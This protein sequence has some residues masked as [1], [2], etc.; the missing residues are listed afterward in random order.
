MSLGAILPL[1]RD[2]AM[3][4]E[5]LFLFN[6]LL[7][8][9]S[10]IFVSLAFYAVSEESKG[11]ML[12]FIVFWLL[13]VIELI[14]LLTV[15]GS[16]AAAIGWTFWILFTLLFFI[17]SLAALVYAILALNNFGKGLKAYVNHL[18]LQDYESSL[19]LQ[20]A[21]IIDAENHRDMRTWRSEE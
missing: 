19:F 10:F 20:K 12:A 7:L 13:L 14:Y 18:S 15:H 2:T 16:S 11:G 5:Y 3:S 9:L 17:I 21:K 1:I 6:F 8:L 4:D